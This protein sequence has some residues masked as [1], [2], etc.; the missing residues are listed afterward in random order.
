[1]RTEP[2]DGLPPIQGDRVQLQQVILNLIINA[3]EAMSAL[4]E[5]ARELL[6]SSRKAGADGVLV[7]V[8]DSG[9]G[10]P[11]ATLEH[12]FRAF[13]TTK[14]GDLG[15]GLSICR[16]IVEAHGGQLWASQNGPRGAIF[17]VHRARRPGVIS[18]L[19]AA[20]CRHASLRTEALDLAEFSGA[21]RP[22]AQQRL[23]QPRRAVVPHDAGAT[24]PAQNAAV[25]RM[26]LVAVDVTDL[27][28]PDMDFDSATAGA[29][30]AGSLGHSVCHIWGGFHPVIFIGGACIRERLLRRCRVGAPNSTRAHW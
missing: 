22:A 6:V 25:Y 7:A 30:V 3:V 4:S 18:A 28:V 8:R 9:S 20:I 13:Y 27:T 21:A 2:A 14:P 29:H 24:L 26:V 5:G 1:V 16:S 11:A 12:L 19:G 23:F 17:S 10:F 15:H